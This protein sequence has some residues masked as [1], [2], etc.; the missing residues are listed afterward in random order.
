MLVGRIR[1]DL[2]ESGRNCLQYL[3]KGWNRT[4]GRG[5]DTKI[6][7]NPWVKGWVPEKGGGLEP[8]YEL[9]RKIDHMYKKVCK[10]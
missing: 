1:R 7:K 9:L 10:N 3:K 2:H 8:P 4:E 6:L 5:G